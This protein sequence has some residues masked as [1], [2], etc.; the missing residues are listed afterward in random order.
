MKTRYVYA[1]L[2]SLTLTAGLTVGCAREV[3][4]TET[5][6]P[7]LLGGHV[8][9]ESTTVKHADGTYT[10]EKSKSVSP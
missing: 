2:A 7:R 3:E 1:A 9:E 6:K 10:T 5:D 4:H 8:H